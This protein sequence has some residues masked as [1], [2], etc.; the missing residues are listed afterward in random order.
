MN[1]LE[2]RYTTEEVAEHYR[3]KPSTVQRWVREKRITAINLG[4]NRL[5][6]YVFRPTD[7]EEFEQRS[8][9]KREAEQESEV[10]A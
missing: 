2:P 8:E 1:E 4:G 7:L 9:R 10:S 6:P 3:V 5:G